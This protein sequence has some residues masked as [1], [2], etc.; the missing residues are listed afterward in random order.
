MGTHG[1]RVL[2]QGPLWGIRA[3]AR[4]Q[5]VGGTV[6][7]APVARSLPRRKLP[8]T[9]EPCASA[10]ASAGLDVGSLYVLGE[11]LPRRPFNGN[12]VPRSPGL[13]GVLPFHLNLAA[14]DVVDGG[15]LPHHLEPLLGLTILPEVVSYVLV[16]QVVGI[17]N[18]RRWQ[19]VPGTGAST[20]SRRTSRCS[21]CTR[22]C[23]CHAVVRQRIPSRGG[24][25][26]A[27]VA[28]ASAPWLL[29]PKLRSR[30]R[31]RRW[32]TLCRRG[33]TARVL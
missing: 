9:E 31:G 7:D 33:N 30:P 4:Q 18:I 5:V 24:L 19:G 32:S 23:C 16:E 22:R 14:V 11:R 20:R 26:V 27:S 12:E 29:P 1:C 6:V 21:R 15:A 8:H 2:P 10:S 28:L 17:T 25:A 3:P 13:L